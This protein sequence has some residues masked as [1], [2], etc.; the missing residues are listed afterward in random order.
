MLNALVAD[1]AAV[2]GG[3]VTA[4]VILGNGVIVGTGVQRHAAAG[5]AAC[6]TVLSH[7]VVV[8]IQVIVF[9]IHN[10]DGLSI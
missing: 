4:D 7:M 10:L 2:S 8:D 6:G 3:K 9:S 5:G 1:A